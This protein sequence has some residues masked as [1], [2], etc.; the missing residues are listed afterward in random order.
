MTKRT[1]KVKPGTYNLVMWQHNNKPLM[2]PAWGDNSRIKTL[3]NC[4]RL[5]VLAVGDGVNW[6]RRG[7]DGRRERML[8]EVPCPAQM[9]YYCQTFHLINK[10]NGAEKTYDMGGM[11]R[12]HNRPPKIIF[13]LI[14]MTMANAYQ[15]Y[16]MMVTEQMPDCKC[17]LMKNMIKKLM[18]SLMQRGAPMRTRE[19]SHPQPDIDL[20]QLHG[21]MLGE[22]VR[23]DSRRQA[24]AEEGHHQESWVEYFVLRG[25]QKKQAWQ[26]HQSVGATAR[27]RCCWGKCPRLKKAKKR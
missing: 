22:K 1:K 19:A 2:F 17:L 12:M 5:E 7:N 14:S 27:G 8:M 10:G 4:L 6:K 23:L 16:C 20:S 21:W 11:S 15:I 26:Q 9:K 18:F 25:M 3:S 24:V 13:Q